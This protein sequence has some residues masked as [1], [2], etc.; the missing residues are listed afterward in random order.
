MILEVWSSVSRA[1]CPLTMNIV[2]QQ[3]HRQ[4]APGDVTMG[5]A[6]EKA[7][8]LNTKL[9]FKWKILTSTVWN[10]KKIIL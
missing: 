10:L 5:V 1:Q 6:Y 9:N 3:F 7:L 4:G 2:R 8:A